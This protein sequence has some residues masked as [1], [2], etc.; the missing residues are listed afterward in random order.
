MDEVGLRKKRTIE[1][2]NATPLFW[3]TVRGGLAQY[4]LI[5][6][7]RVFDQSSPRNMDTILRLTYESREHVFSKH[8]LAGRKRAG[9]D[10]A[11]EW[12]AAFMERASA[13]TIADFK[14]LSRLVK[15]Y[16]KIYEFQYQDIRNKTLGHTEIVDD[17]ELAALYAKTN[18]RDLERL[19]IF[20]NKFH[21]AL[22]ELFYNGRRPRL[23]PICGFRAEVSLGPRWPIC[24]GMPSTRTSSRRRENPWRSSLKPSMRATNAVELR[25]FDGGDSRNLEMDESVRPA[26]DDRAVRLSPHDDAG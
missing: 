4:A 20:L 26:A 3:I 2:L 9:S 23:R 12:L 13:P 16:R 21:K 14:R 25:V 6:L 22:W 5:A 7:G 8:A 11:D 15:K 18:I 10:N 24:A 17:T 19:L 1:A